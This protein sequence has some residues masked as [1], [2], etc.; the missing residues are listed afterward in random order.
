MLDYLKKLIASNSEESSKRF[1]AMY[2]VLFIGTIIT[3]AALF[4]GADLII[5]LGVWLSF[6]TTLWG[7]SEYNKNIKIKNIK[8]ENDDVL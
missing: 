6:A 2:I 8:K 7:M 1:A 5:L 3:V 4:N